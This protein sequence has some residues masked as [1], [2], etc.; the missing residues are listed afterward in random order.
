MLEK[1]RQSSK[2]LVSVQGLV[3]AGMLL[4]LYAVLGTFKIPISPDNRISLTFAATSTAGFVLGPVPAVII[5]GLGDLMGFIMNPGGSAFFPGFTL[6]AMLGG[7]VYGMI[8]YKAPFNR[9]LIV[10]IVAAVFIITLF[11]NIILNTYWLSI[12]YD[13]AYTI[14]AIPRI[15]KNLIAFPVHIAVIYAMFALFE[16]T[17]MRRKYLPGNNVKTAFRTE[18][19]S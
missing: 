15:L 16:K 7:L 4:A 18:I 17:G 12:L 19:N 8:F 1:F 6:S 2:N 14:F 11:V 9:F 3:L 10:R 13:K 5:G